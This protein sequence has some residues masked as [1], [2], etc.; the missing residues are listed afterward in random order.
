MTVKITKG[1]KFTE[2]ALPAK[3]EHEQGAARVF[4]VTATRATRKLVIGM[5]G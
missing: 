1:L 3:G 4:H 2:V 5:G